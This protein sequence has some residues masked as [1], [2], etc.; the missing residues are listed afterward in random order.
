MKL[1]HFTKSNSRAL[2]LAL[3]SAL[4]LGG[5]M[6]GIN[7]YAVDVTGSMAADATVS[8]SCSLSTTKV[9]FGT[10]NPVSTHSST[11]VD[12]DNTGA[13][14]VTCT[15]G[16]SVT[17]KLDDGVNNPTTSSL[18]A[19]E[20]RLSNGATT[21]VYLNYQL[22]KDSARTAVWDTSTGVNI[23]SATGAAESLTV[24]GR[25]L[26]GQNVGAGTYTDT[27]AVTASY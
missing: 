7:S 25:V 5:T 10:Y 26:K 4:A 18:T 20:R 14:T 24:Y 12:L 11:G 16:T 8:A 23:A 15:K 13:V 27:V 9:A 6:W 1:K 19:P 17:V 21:P 22:Y 3:G 2:R